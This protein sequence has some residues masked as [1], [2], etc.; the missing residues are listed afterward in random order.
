MSDALFWSSLLLLVAS[1]VWTIWR[2]RGAINAAVLVP[3]AWLILIPIPV[4]IRP[5][6]A[7]AKSLFP[8]GFVG[9][10]KDHLY[11]SI[12]IANVAFAG[13]QWLILSGWFKGVR[14]RTVA[15]I[16]GPEQPGNGKADSLL[17]N[18]VIGL[19]LVAVALAIT[20]LALM[21][22]VPSWDLVT[23]YSDPLQ[24]NYD[25]EAA[26]KLSLIHI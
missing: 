20:H 21:P 16:V 3:L 19:T 12:A 14:S 8:D 22:R 10:P 25:R 2:A 26:D 1:T 24:L 5:W 4:L 23:G 9:A 6:V 18:W 15:L 13:F 7:T 11:I 17:R